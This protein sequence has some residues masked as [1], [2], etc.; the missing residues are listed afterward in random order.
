MLSRC[1]LVGLAL[2]PLG[3]AALPAPPHVDAVDIISRSVAAN[4]SDWRAEP[5]YDHCEQD[6]DGESVKTYDVTMIEGTPYERLVAIDGRPLPAGAAHDEAHKIARTVA[7]RRDES[8]S[9]RAHR[10]ADYRNTHERMRA[11]FDQLTT[12]FDFTLKGTRRVAGRRVFDIAA[13]PR[14]DYQP[15]TLD[16]KALTGMTAEFWIDATSHRWMR[17]DARVTQPVSLVGLLVRVQ[18]GTAITL[19]KAQVGGVW[20]TTRLRIQSSS[21]LL[22]FIRHRAYED[23]RYFDYRPS[24][25]HRASACGAGGQRSVE[26]NAPPQPSLFSGPTGPADDTLHGAAHFVTRLPHSPR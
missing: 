19:E 21:R 16:A 7:E 5:N 24:A 18:P 26:A 1:A 10:L 11:L 20:Q 12:A 4:E 15:P 22:F 14:A 2:A 9:D 8:P 17:V 6:D 3:R 23:D 13:K 25:S